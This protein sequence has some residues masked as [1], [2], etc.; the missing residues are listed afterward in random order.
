[1]KALMTSNKSEYEVWSL[2]K[3]N[4]FAYA[5]RKEIINLSYFL[6]IAK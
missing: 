5:V 2:S 4:S 1:M 6:S 3:D